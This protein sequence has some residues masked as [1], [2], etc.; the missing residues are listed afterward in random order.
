M[1]ATATELLASLYMISHFLSFVSRIDSVLLG[2][3][4]I[5]S[6]SRVSTNYFCAHAASMKLKREDRLSGTF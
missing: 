5:A 4:I 1:S 2:R 6:K 3:V